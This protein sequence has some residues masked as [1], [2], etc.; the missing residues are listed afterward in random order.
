MNRWSAEARAARVEAIV[1][2]VDG[3]LTRGD[4]IY[5]PD[6][7]GLKTFDVRDGLGFALARQA[8]LRLALLS[9]RASEALR[10]RAADLKV[11]AMLEGVERK[12]AALI[13]LC[14]IMRVKS[15][16]VC[17]VGDDLIDLP[18]M[19]EAG[20]PVAVADAVEEVRA[21]AAWV[22]SRPGGA[23]AA[24]ETIEYILKAKGKWAVIV[25]QYAEG[26]G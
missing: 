18:A 12:G 17:Y 19:R 21:R 13:E 16:E 22:T 2:D 15:A 6:G 14:G 26:D 9:G 11:D 23:G 7:D 5:G 3:V 10:R 25:N 24:R 20:F 8:G 1:F 4:L